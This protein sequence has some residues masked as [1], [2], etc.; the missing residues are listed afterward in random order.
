MGLVRSGDTEH[1]R[2]I[3]VK[4]KEL[5]KSLI[6]KGDAYS[7]QQVEIQHLT[8]EAWIQLN[9]GNN[10]EALAF[11]E[12]ASAMEAATAKHPVTPGEVLP[13]GELL[14][15]LHLQL[16]NYKLALEAYE[17]DM[18]NHPNRFNGL[19]GAAIAARNA[20]MADKAL[21]YFKKLLYNTKASSE[22]RMEI[23]DAR[24][25]VNQHAS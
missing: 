20:G 3:L 16:G 11:M 2:E 13:A 14:G 22:Q 23:L 10:A 24:T 19:Y 25:F 18:V 12:K 8:L 4:L 5:H 21:V 15:D 7:A 17:A 6:D 1:A 9:S